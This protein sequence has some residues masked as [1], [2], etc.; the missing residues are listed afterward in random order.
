MTTVY[1]CLLFVSGCTNPIF[2]GVSVE[3]IILQQNIDLKGNKYKM[4]TRN[5]CENTSNVEGECHIEIILMPVI[6][7]NILTLTNERYNFSTGSLV[8]LN[9]VCRLI[10]VLHHENQFIFALQLA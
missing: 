4:T 1:I 7:R 9:Q 2:G 10:I 6:F 5:V 8:V 3:K